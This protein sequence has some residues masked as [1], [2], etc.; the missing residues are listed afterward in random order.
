ML[1]HGSKV[2][3]NVIIHG[4]GGFFGFLIFNFA[5][6]FFSF[7]FCICSDNRYCTLYVIYVFI[8][9]VGIYSTLINPYIVSP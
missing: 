8:R 7:G 6:W 1:F 5:F 9:I 2:R 3:G 4:S